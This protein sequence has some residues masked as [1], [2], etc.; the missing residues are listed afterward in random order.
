MT[1]V[2]RSVARLPLMA[3]AF[4]LAFAA[5]AFAQASSGAP[6][7]TSVSGAGGGERSDLT[8]SVT[9]RYDDNVTRV[10]DV[11]PNLQNLKRKDV[12]ISPALQLNAARN[13]GRHQ[14]GIRSYLGYDFYTR[15]SIL[16]RERLVVEPFA[17]LDLPVCDLGVDALASRSQ[18]DLGD[19]VYLGIDPT[20]G[21][22][23]TETRKRVSGRLSCGDSYG[24]RP[25]F[26]VERASGFNSN[27]LRRLADY[28][29][30]RIQPGV[31]Y[32]SP[33]LGEVSLYVVRT[34]TDLPNQILPNGQQAG[35]TL[36]GVGASYRR[37]IGTRLNFNGSLSHVDVTPYGG[38]GSRS[39]LNASVSLTLLASER[40]QFVAFANRNFTSNLS[41]NATYELAEGY[42]LTA[43]YAANDRLRFRLGGQYSPRSFYYAVTPTGPFIGSQTQYDIFGGASY[44]LNR[45]VR[46][47][48]DIGAQRRDAD[49]DFFDYRSFYAATGIAISL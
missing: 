26:E 49:L 19:L 28:T 46:L 17:F 22:E 32:A 38:Q 41:S 27:L 34:D 18:S 14:I 2:A 31:G 12:R 3:L 21:A 10:N 44:N 5:P 29:V 48:F 37:A 45:R 1:Q 36:R 6:S 23:N 33:A 16:N 8:F 42:G 43:N 7:G 4:A 39:G 35:Y 47:N 15:N 11:R 30:T 24:L 9:A 13:I 40:L 20:L 25:T